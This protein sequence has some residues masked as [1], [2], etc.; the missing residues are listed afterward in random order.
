[1]MFSLCRL[2]VKDNGINA[3]TVHSSKPKYITSTYLDLCVVVV[4]A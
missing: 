2:C 4:I 3:K 1:M